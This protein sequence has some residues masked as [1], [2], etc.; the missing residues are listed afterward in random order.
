MLIIPLSEI[1][2]CQKMTLKQSQ[3]PLQSQ[4]KTLSLPPAPVLN[5]TCHLF[6]GF[7]TSLLEK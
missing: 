6:A 1:Y 3:I 7:E 5:V 2:F 4:I